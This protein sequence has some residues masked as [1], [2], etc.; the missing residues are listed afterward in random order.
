MPSQTAG[1]SREWL[2]AAEAELRTEAWLVP[3]PLDLVAAVGKGLADARRQG[4]SER[5]GQLNRRMTAAQEVGNDEEVK[6]LVAKAR[7]AAQQYGLAETDAMLAPCRT[8]ENWL[9]TTR[10][11]RRTVR[12]FEHA[13][14]RLREGLRDG[15]DW[16]YVQEY[17]REA[18]SYG[19]ELPAD[20]ADA[21]AAR[22]RRRH[23]LFRAISLSVGVGVAVMIGVLVAWQFG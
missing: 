10:T 14:G 4:A 6:R 13:V 9:S 12:Q 22:A 3:P 23:V 18:Q 21:F 8:A 11:R 16:W 1:V 17:Y 15:I 19:R 5:L 2:E 7:D 20:V